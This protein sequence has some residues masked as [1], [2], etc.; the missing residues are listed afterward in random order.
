MA[1]GHRQRRRAAF[2]RRDPLLQH[3]IGRVADAGIDV[4]E[5]LQPEERGGMVDIVEDEGGGLVDRRGAGAGRGIGSG[6]GMDGERVET[7]CA[8]GH[9]QLPEAF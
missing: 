3:R 9:V 1:G 2:Q 6:A 7:R 4:A 5:G 8:V